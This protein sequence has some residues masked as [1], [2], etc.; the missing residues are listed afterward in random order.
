MVNVIYPDMS[1]INQST[2]SLIIIFVI[3]I[4]LQLRERRVKS[5][6]LMLMPAF[7]FLITA[8]IVYNVLFSDI[9]NFTLIITGFILGIGLG[10]LIGSFMKV[11][12][13]ENGSMMLKGSAIAVGLWLLVI[14]LKIYGKDILSGTGLINLDVLISMVLMMTLGAMISRRFYVYM[15]Y[16]KHKQMLNGQVI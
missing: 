4:L 14:A 11:R 7:M 6:K 3:I 1:M 16:L 5:W 10:I 2:Q 9:L 12:I 13:D 15:K 8:G